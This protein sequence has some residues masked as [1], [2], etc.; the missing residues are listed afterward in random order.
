MCKDFRVLIMIGDPIL[1]VDE[2]AKR[3][4]C[5]DP[6]LAENPRWSLYHEDLVDN[7]ISQD[8]SSRPDSLKR[9]ASLVRKS[10]QFSRLTAIFEPKDRI[11]DVINGRANRGICPPWPNLGLAHQIWMQRPARVSADS[12]FFIIHQAE[13]LVDQ[14]SICPSSTI[15]VPPRLLRAVYHDSGSNWQT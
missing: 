4:F 12:T 7:T 6:I 15:Q 5:T 10:Y 2:N 13:V 11:K 3:L 8:L 1:K 14:A 9:V